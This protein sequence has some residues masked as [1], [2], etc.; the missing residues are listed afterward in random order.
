LLSVPGIG[1]NPLRA[2]NSH[3]PSAVSALHS[4][5]SNGGT[6]AIRSQGHDSGSSRH[7]DHK[8]ARRNIQTR[9]P[10]PSQSCAQ[11]S[12][13]HRTIQNLRRV[14]CGLRWR[15]RWRQR[16]RQGSSPFRA[17][18]A[19][20]TV[21]KDILHKGIPSGGDRVRLLGCVRRCYSGKEDPI[22]ALTIWRNV[23]K[24][25]CDK[26]DAYHEVRAAMRTWTVLLCCCPLVFVSVPPAAA[27]QAGSGETC[28]AVQHNVAHKIQ[29]KGNFTC[30]ATA[31]TK[32]TLGDPPVCTKTTYYENCVAALSHSG[33]VPIIPQTG[34]MKRRQ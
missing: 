4:P 5:L 29:G 6:D 1:L 15:E 33:Q 31:C 9:C 30:D 17:S 27:H 19:S 8:K 11:S 20:A 3:H 10:I 25:S 18:V 16:R 26:Q 24:G 12:P 21:R 7:R 34:G 2:S 28:G 22:R 14:K 23:S 13:H 32:C